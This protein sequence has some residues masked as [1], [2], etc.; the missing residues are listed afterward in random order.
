MEL[1]TRGKSIL[2]S[3][4][5]WVNGVALLAALLQTQTGLVMDAEAQMATLA[6]INFILRMITRQPIAWSADQKGS[7]RPGVLLVLLLAFGGG[8]SACAAWQGAP[9]VENS[10]RALLSAKETIVTLAVSADEMCRQ[11]T[12]DQERCT[13]LGARYVQAGKSYDLVESLL[14]LA[15]ADPA[16]QST[17]ARLIAAKE[18]FF[19]IAGDMIVAAASYGVT[20]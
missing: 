9:A 2:T 14:G 4:T 6:L 16:D 15:L 3:K 10:G 11:G 18:R 7:A 12:L 5:M 13:D 8:I 19:T 17:S 20:P 1:T